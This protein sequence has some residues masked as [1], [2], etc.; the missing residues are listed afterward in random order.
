MDNQFAFDT[1]TTVT[2]HGPHQYLGHLHQRWTIGSVP[3]GGYAMAIMLRAAARESSHPDPLTA[4]A[5]FLS[6]T[7]AGPVE[8]R[9]EV[10]KSGRSTSTIMLALHQEERERIRMLTTMG[11]LSARRGPTHEYLAPPELEGP[12][13]SRRSPLLQEFPNNFEYRIPHRVAGAVF[14]EPTGHPEIGGTIAFADGRPPDL[15]SMPVMAD[16]FAPVVFNLGYT[17]WTPT[18]EMTVHFWRKPAPGPLTV[19][20]HSGVIEAG[21]HDESSDIWDSKGHLVA[22][23]RQFAIILSP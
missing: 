14:G 18:L 17:N 3:N 9:S 13:E 11:E 12:F 2:S 19:W 22:R 20:L 5:H 21:F 8:I 15:L 4:T 7:G 23:S 16:G 10:V 1:D 6:P